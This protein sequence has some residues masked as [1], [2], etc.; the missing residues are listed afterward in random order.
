MNEWHL[1]S[2][3]LVIGM[4]IASCAVMIFFYAA[5][6][7]TATCH[8]SAFSFNTNNSASGKIFLSIYC[9]NRNTSLC[10]GKIPAPIPLINNHTFI[11]TIIA[12][13]LQLTKTKS[14]S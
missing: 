11:R 14:T 9:N 13:S 8:L 7:F 1:I 4:I 2:L 3:C 12:I 6:V 5:K 10:I